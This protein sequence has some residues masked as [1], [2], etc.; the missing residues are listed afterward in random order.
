M[1]RVQEIVGLPFQW[2]GQRHSGWLPKG[3]GEPKPVPVE[4]DVLDIQI[5]EESGGYLLIWSGRLTGRHGDT[6]H[7]TLK[8]S[9]QQAEANFDIVPGQWVRAIVRRAVELSFPTD[10]QGVMEKLCALRKGYQAQAN[11]LVLAHGNADLLRRCSEFVNED[12]R[13]DLRSG[14]DWK[15][16]YEKDALLPEEIARRFEALGLPVPDLVAEQV[17]ERQARRR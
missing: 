1:S 15:H 17:K 3:A 16:S 4:P 11:V 7:E 5:D 10:V 12:W 13:E 14:I 2:G 9:E 6:W 8:Q